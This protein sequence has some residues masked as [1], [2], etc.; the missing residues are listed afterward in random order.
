LRDALVASIHFNIFH[1]D[2]ERVVMTNVAQTFNVLQ[3][4]ILAEGDRMIL[5]PTYHV[6]EM[7]KQHQDAASLP[8]HLAS[9]S[10]NRKVS[11]KTRDTLSVSASAKDGRVLTR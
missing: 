7:N 2:A 4:M 8:V 6:F 5:T 11:G 1:R 3:A 9:P 10:A